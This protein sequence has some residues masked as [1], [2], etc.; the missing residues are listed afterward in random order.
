MTTRPTDQEVEALLGRFFIDED[1]GAK[2]RIQELKDALRAL[3]HERRQRDAELRELVADRER[4]DWLAARW[5][6][7]DAGSSDGRMLCEIT[8]REGSCPLPTRHVDDDPW[9]E[10]FADGTLTF[11]RAID[12][13][14]QST[15]RTDVSAANP[16]TLRDALDATQRLA[17][18]GTARTGDGE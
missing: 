18:K 6:V 9:Y 5:T 12:A 1:T 8:M 11:R 15:A 13:A 4:L 2:R 10:S 3:L 17:G 14:R 16:Y 7:Y